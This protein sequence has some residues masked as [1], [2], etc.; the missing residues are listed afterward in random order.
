M[1]KHI[2]AV[3]D[4]ANADEE[5][6][7][8][9]QKNIAADHRV[10]KESGKYPYY[11]VFCNPVEKFSTQASMEKENWR[12]TLFATKDVKK[13]DTWVDR[14]YFD[15]GELNAINNPSRK[16]VEIEK[17]YARIKEEHGKIPRGK[18]E[19]R[20]PYPHGKQK[21][22]I[23]SHYRF[24][25]MVCGR[26]FGKTTAALIAALLQ[27]VDKPESVIFYIAPTYRQAKNIA[28]SMLGRMVG[29]CYK[30]KSE[31]ELSIE[32]ANGSKIFL[33]GADNPDS[34]RGTYVHL[35]I[36]DE[37]ADMRPNVWDEI[38]APQLT[39]TRGRAWFLGT[40]R[41]YDHFYK[42]WK[43]AHGGD[44][45]KDWGAFR[46]TTYD[47]PH[48]PRDEIDRAKIA[49][50]PRSFSQEYLAEF[51][52]FEGLVF[53]DFER[54]KHVMDF[55]LKKIR[56]FDLCGLDWG[57]D[58]PT[59]GVYV[60][61]GED[62]KFYVWG[63]HYERNLTVEEHVKRLKKIEGRGKVR[64]RYL[65]PSAK[66]VALDL[67]KNGLLTQK[68]CNDRIYGIDKVRALLREGRLVIHPSC[69]NLIY[70]FEHH[71]Y[72]SEKEK[73]SSQ[74]SDVDK[75]VKKL[76][77][78]ACFTGAVR[79]LC[80][81]GEK[82]IDEVRV[83][84]YVITPYG[85]SKVLE[86]KKTGRE[87]TYRFGR[88]GVTGNHPFF[89]QEGLVRFDELRYGDSVCRINAN[90]SLWMGSLL[91]VTRNQ[92]R[93][94]IGSISAV[95]QRLKQA[96]KQND[97]I[98]IFGSGR[99]GRFLRDMSYTTRTMTLLITSSIIWSYLLIK[100]IA[101]GIMKRTY[102]GLKKIW[103]MLES[104]Q[105]NGM[106]QKR[107]WSFING[108]VKNHGRIRSSMKR[109]ARSVEISIL[110]RSLVD[111]SI[112]KKGNQKIIVDRGR[113]EKEDVYNLATEHGM[114][115]A[116]GCLVSN[117]DAL[118]Y[119]LATYLKGRNAE[120]GQAERMRNEYENRGVKREFDR[121]NLDNNRNW[122]Q[123]GMDMVAEE[124]KDLYL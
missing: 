24:K 3:I 27:A 112:A 108:W 115:Y 74:E 107:G 42:L 93:W 49:T 75:A 84:D 41:G 45:G 25:V 17:A 46:L 87:E 76:D 110:H 59:A 9:K 68:A 51:V 118:R 116:N 73:R 43:E 38:I 90:K 101:I 56:G 37:Y 92:K 15:S 102:L 120:G 40:P 83:G 26:R 4:R 29:E 70:E 100:N 31:Q 69:V 48:I 13:G 60:R 28:W 18:D 14:T 39:D 32:L 103:N 78:D 95:R 85:K 22:I 88:G 94:S 2:Q 124:F 117:C 44:L 11:F 21:T 71:R 81:G 8:D 82:R 89:T 62:G 97:C 122:S 113:L 5:G 114:Y 109:F 7:G 96:L 111:L 54:G 30:R 10:R 63:E 106:G 6:L 105:V 36:L 12:G 58:H 64:K 123:E 47:N 104:L 20:L 77:D 65:D 1:G 19:L 33:K 50:D 86:V 66:Q 57:A 99:M 72:K 61:L 67:K 91:D 119:A 35:A 80:E 16:K 53:G 34:L 52:Q 23:Y 98:G 55:D 121:V 79:V